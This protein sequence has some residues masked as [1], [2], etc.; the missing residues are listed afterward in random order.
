MIQ[1][2]CRDLNSDLQLVIYD[3][4]VRFSQPPAF[5]KKNQPP[6]K[7]AP[8]KRIIP[9]LKSPLLKKIDFIINKIVIIIYQKVLKRDCLII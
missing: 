9:D 3:R 5:K 7:K 1:W 8:A 6:Q 4:L 2:G